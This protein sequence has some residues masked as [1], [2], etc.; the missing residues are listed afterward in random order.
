MDINSLMSSLLS[1]DSVSGLSQNT[2]VSAPD[3]QNVLAQALPM[4]LSGANQQ[5][6]ESATSEGF[7]GALLQHAAKDTSDI[8][9]FLKDVDVEDGAKIIAHLLGQQTAQKKKEVSAKTGV[10][11]QL[12]GEILAMAAPLLMSLLGQQ[13]QAAQTADADA[14]VGNLMTTLLGNVDVADIAMA[15]IGGKSKKK[16]MKFVTKLLK[17]LLK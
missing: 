1:A 5:A 4:L 2:G 13:T 10:S 16:K 12:T 11:D 15:L 8:S 3:V 6:A 9:A 7:A 17:N 14:S